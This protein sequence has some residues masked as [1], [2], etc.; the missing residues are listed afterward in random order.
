MNLWSRFHSLHWGWK[1][2]LLFLFPPLIIIVPLVAY[3]PSN[4]KQRAYFL[5]APLLVLVPVAILVNAM[6]EKQL[7]VTQDQEPAKTAEAPVLSPEVP[8][9]KEDATIPEKPYDRINAIVQK[10]DEFSYIVNVENLEGKDPQPPYE[11]MIVMTN[12][13]SCFAAKSKALNIMRDL[14][15]DPVSS[16]AIVRVMVSNNTY[17][18][19][20]LGANDAH[21]ITAQAW[22]RNGPTRFIEALEGSANYDLDLVQNPTSKTIASYT[23]AELYRGCL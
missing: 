1:I 13:E 5:V 10:Y 18:K 20:S 16:A 23:Y 3:F 11:V 4:P 22:N 6:H 17:F 8:E 14:Y 15:L 19:A 9:K 7:Q 2:A 21:S 12:V